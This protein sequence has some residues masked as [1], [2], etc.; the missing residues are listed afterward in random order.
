MCILVLFDRFGR[1]LTNIR[2]M[3]TGACNM[4]CFFCHMEGYRQ[5]NTHIR[6]DFVNVLVEASR[7]LGVLSFKLTGGEPLLH[8]QICEV[9]KAIRDKGLKV[10]IT[11]NGFYLVNYVNQLADL[12]VDHINVS[13]HSLRR[14]TY[15]Y[16]TGVDALNRVLEGIKEAS[17]HGLKVKINFVVLKGVNDMELEKVMDFARKYAARLQVIEL[18]PVGK[19]KG[20]FSKFHLPESEII[21]RL[22]S[23]CREVRIRKDLHNRP[24]IVMND[25]FEVEVV[26]PVGNWAFCAACTRIRV[27][28][29]GVMLPCLNWRGRPVD[30]SLCL[31]EKNFNDKVS[32]MI[33]KIVL[34]NSLRRPTYMLN[35]KSLDR[36][37]PW[38]RHVV[39]LGIPK[40]NGT[41]SFIGGFN[42]DK[43]LKLFRQTL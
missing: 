1:P 7:R 20:V 12:G 4:R 23:R 14:E 8:P 38:R 16:I 5:A 10:S 40:A 42:E 2:L 17:N 3:V 26:G 24:I 31:K 18:H 6:L 28:Y 21:K 34:V 33:S 35:V 32:C 9:I 11:T 37:L 29:D 43:Y 36:P 39:R 41:M 27:S 22:V 30:A 13:L 25:G 15:K 19:G